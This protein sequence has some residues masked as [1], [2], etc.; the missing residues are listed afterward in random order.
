VSERLTAADLEQLSNRGDLSPF[1]EQ[2]RA[3]V[4][5]LEKALRE[6]ETLLTNYLVAGKF[7]HGSDCEEVR[8]IFRA[9]L[10]AAGEGDATEGSQ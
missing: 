8:D 4:T 5:E 9:T 7:P 3:R 1:E 6:G 10:A 2:L